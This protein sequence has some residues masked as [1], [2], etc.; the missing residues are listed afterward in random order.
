[1]DIFP[2]TLMVAGPM[3]FPRRTKSPKRVAF[4]FPFGRAF[5]EDLVHAIH[6]HAR[7]REH[8]AFTRFPERLSPS[9][10]WLKA[11]DGDGAF[12]IISTREDARLA[13][14]L[15][16]PVVNLT[17]YFPDPG[18]PTVTM[19]HAE[20]GRLAARH[21]L[22]RRFRN[23]GF[24]GAGELWFSQLRQQGFLETVRRAGAACEVLEAN[25]NIASGRTWMR[26][27]LKLE[28]WLRSL[29][30]PVGILA[31]TDLRANLL[32]E[33]CQ[34]IGRRV[35]E[36]IAVIG[37]DNDPVICG[38]SQ[39]PLSSV[40]RDDHRA[41]E[42]AAALLAELMAGRS[43]RPGPVLVAPAGV[44]ARQSTE[45]MAVG[46]PALAGLV[47][48]VGEHIAERF[49]VERLLAVTRWSRRSLE[50]RFRRQLGLTPGAFVTGLRLKHAEKMLAA[51]PKL[52]LTSVAAACGFSDLRHF[53]M[54]FRRLNGVSPTAHR[55]KLR[56]RLTP[57]L[58]AP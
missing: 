30:P 37:V 43:A 57:P 3:P 28:Q 58:P 24:Y 6:A 45:T 34:Q 16:F 8:W 15:P 12:V 50:T 20:V 4:A 38:Y 54:V 14:A 25:S 1:M 55:R 18:V 35:P 41:G 17:A 2:Q 52:P 26:Q 39:P 53:R 51:N 22:E 27:Q 5:V 36:E 19:D 44:V 21:L 46:D 23:F 33:T 32:L 13:R 56:R 11:W 31:S 29:R 7:A 47:Q 48:H 42:V 9:L 49:G 40:A 10:D